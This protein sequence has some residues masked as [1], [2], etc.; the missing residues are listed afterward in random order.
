MPSSPRRPDLLPLTARADLLSLPLSRAAANSFLLPLTERAIS[1]LLPLTD[2]ANS[3]LL[4][5]AAA[6][7][8]T[9]PSAACPNLLP[10]PPQP[11]PPPLPPLPSSRR[12]ASPHIRISRRWHSPSLSPQLQG[13]LLAAAAAASRGCRLSRWKRAARRGR[14]EAGPGR[15]S[16]AKV[17][18]SRS[19]AQHLRQQQQPGGRWSR[20]IQA[21]R[22][23]SSSM[24]LGAAAA[25][26]EESRAAAVLI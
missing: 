22:H 11:P 12:A 26:Q 2:R 9:S 3:S 8:S 15:W 20:S 16:G 1:S 6:A 24:R 18:G 21:Q 17:W 19:P 10:P 23:P 7:S 14:E 25:R 13:F 4:P 5:S